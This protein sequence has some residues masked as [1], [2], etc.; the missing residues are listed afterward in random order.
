MTGKS[1]AECH[2]DD[3][4][5]MV[6]VAARYP[7]YDEREENLVNLEQR[8]NICRKRYQTADPLPFESED[9]LSLTAF[10]A[11]QSKGMPI[12]VDVSGAARPYFEAGRAYF[13]QRRGTAQPRMQPLPRE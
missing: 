11:H 2:G 7:A 13:Y 1:C 8:I 5:D 9:L 12:N 10:I 6:G 4:R 3:G